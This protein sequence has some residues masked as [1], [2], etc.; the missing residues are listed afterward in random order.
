MTKGDR[1]MTEDPAEAFHQVNGGGA[2]HHRSVNLATVEEEEV[3]LVLEDQTATGMDEE[4]EDGDLSQVNTSQQYGHYHGH[5]LALCS[6]EAEL[7]IRYCVVLWE[8]GPRRNESKAPVTQGA[9][10]R[11]CKQRA[12]SIGNR[13]PLVPIAG[14]TEMTSDPVIRASYG[15]WSV[16]T[17]SNSCPSATEVAV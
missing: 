10:D 7:K 14:Y 8:H 13:A 17:T 3:V 16:A 6:T 12:K 5:A 2:K 9:M 11:R 15:C 1:T 4:E